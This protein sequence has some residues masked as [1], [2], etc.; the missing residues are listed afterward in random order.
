[1]L[2]LFFSPMGRISRPAYWAVGLPPLLVS[3]V[4]GFV[5]L[6]NATVNGFEFAAQDQGSTA[7]GIEAIASWVSLCAQVKRYHDIGKSGFWILLGFVPIVGTLWV[8]TELSGSRGETGPNRFGPPPGAAVAEDGPGRL[9]DLDDAYF[10]K[11]AA[12]KH[13]AP[14]QPSIQVQAAPSTK[15]PGR[16]V[17]GKRS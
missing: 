16:P 7:I 6:Q 9:A 12:A 1:M 11:L 13:E 14:P 4:T 17:F 3:L 2:Q 8:L 10:K 15:I 5:F